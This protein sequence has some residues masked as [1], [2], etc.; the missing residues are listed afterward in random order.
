MF[1][2]TTRKGSLPLRAHCFPAEDD[3]R[4]NDTH[5]PTAVNDGFDVLVQP[6]ALVMLACA[7]VVVWNLVQ[8]LVRT[9]IHLDLLHTD[10]HAPTQRQTMRHHEIKSLVKK[11][12]HCVGKINNR[13]LL[14]HVLM[15]LEKNE[16][17]N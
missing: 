10:T 2:K 11:D 5:D 7:G 6:A 13:T 14:K 9:S 1:V 8:Q 4:E 15:A 16:N 3:D 17:F 12:N